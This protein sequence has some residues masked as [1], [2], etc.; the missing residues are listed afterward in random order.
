MQ[1][2]GVSYLSLA[3]AP[4]WLPLISDIVYKSRVSSKA[5]IWFIIT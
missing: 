3:S 2:S 1:H 4:V 5:H